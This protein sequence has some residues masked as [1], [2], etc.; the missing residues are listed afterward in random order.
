MDRQAMKDLA[1]SNLPSFD[2]WSGKK[3]IATLENVRELLRA[4][5]IVC[6]YNL[7]SKEEEILVPGLVATT[8]NAKNS[9][10]AYVVSKMV[11]HGLQTNHLGDYLAK[12]CD[13]NPYNPVITWINHEPWDGKNRLDEF[14]ATIDAHNNQAKEWFLYH[15]MVGAVATAYSPDG[16]DSSGVLILQGPQGIGKTWWF[17]KLCPRDL[18]RA[19]ASI[20]TSDKDSVAQVIKYWLVEL[21]ELDATFKKS[22][23]AALKSFITRREDILRMPYA[24]KAS[25]YPRRT[26]FAASVNEKNYLHDTE[27]RRYWT[28]ECKTINSYHDVNMQ[29]V[30]AQI[31]HDWINGASPYLLNEARELLKEINED[32]QQ[33]DPIFEM[34]EQ[35]YYWEN[36][37]SYEWK[38]AT[39]IANDLNLKNITQRETRLITQYVLSLNGNQRKRSNRAKL[40]MVPQVT[41]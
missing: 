26:A 35:K 34:L 5:E 1:T 17:R 39:Q 36:S 2:H 19:D 8:D 29:Q 22:D 33:I 4:K 7:I 10:Y 14:F 6:R 23:I 28:I 15:W 21:G 3:P 31:H 30:W 38:T 18:Q 16:L 40:L 27:N 9:A 41:R 32:H 20:N 13:E 37:I 24:R 11:E 25:N 12:I